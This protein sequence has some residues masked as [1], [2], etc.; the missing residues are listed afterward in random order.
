VSRIRAFEREFLDYMRATHPDVGLA[1]RGDRDLKDTTAE[2]L[3][4]AIL[5]FKQMFSAAAGA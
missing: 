1:I 4:A 3:K 2:R 5:D